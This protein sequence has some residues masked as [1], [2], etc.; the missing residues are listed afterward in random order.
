ME[1]TKPV[2]LA[3]YDWYIVRDDEGLTV[4][5]LNLGEVSSMQRVGENQ[6]SILM[7][8]GAQH[9]FVG[10]VIDKLFTSMGGVL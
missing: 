10:V 7:K 5:I 6:V 1:D 3:K 4:N 8:S 9:I 2:G